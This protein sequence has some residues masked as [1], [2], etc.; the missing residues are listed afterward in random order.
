MS[1][2]WDNIAQKSLETKAD[3]IYENLP[4]AY[5]PSTESGKTYMRLMSFNDEN[6]ELSL[7][8]EYAYHR[9]A[10]PDKDG[11]YKTNSKGDKLTKLSIPCSGS[12]CVYC[13]QVKRLVGNK[14]YSK[15][16]FMY[17]AQTDFFILGVPLKLQSGKFI[18]EDNNGVRPIQL[19]GGYK[20]TLGFLT[21]LKDNLTS[22]DLSVRHPVFSGLDI[23]QIYEKIFGFETGYPLIMD[24]KITPTSDNKKKRLVTFDLLTSQNMPL[25]KSKYNLNKLHNYSQAVLDRAEASLRLSVDGLVGF[26]ET[27]EVPNTKDDDW[28]EEDDP[29]KNDLDGALDEYLD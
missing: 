24:T 10:T 6:G 20:Q 17:G 13:K 11:K 19:G 2:G 14:A 5:Y 25:E 9:I 21:F 26:K 23:G 8:R 7:Y 18:P 22:E 16:A 1:N 12:N 28:G 4:S 15:E 27:P 29:L 3:I